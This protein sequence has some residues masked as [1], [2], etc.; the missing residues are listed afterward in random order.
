[1]KTILLTGWLALLLTSVSTG[2][3]PNAFRPIISEARIDVDGDGKPDHLSY[4]IR[5]WKT[6]Y[7]GLVRITSAGDKILW[8]HQY[9]MMKHD[10]DNWLGVAGDISIPDWVEGFFTN[11]YGYGTKAEHAKLKPA[12][13]DD[14]QIVYAAK[15]AKTTPNKL[16]EEIL[17]QEENILFSYRAEWREDLMALVYVPSLGRFVCYHRGY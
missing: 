7:E 13:L 16:R 14:A 9:L 3:R 12:D 10:L 4:E 1:M 11:K 5:Y 2:Q 6:E 17:S 8:E 15:L